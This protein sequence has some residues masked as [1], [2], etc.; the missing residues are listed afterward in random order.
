MEK[1]KQ[2]QNRL[3]VGKSSENKQKMLEKP[4]HFVAG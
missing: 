2:V 1:I 4:K 3:T